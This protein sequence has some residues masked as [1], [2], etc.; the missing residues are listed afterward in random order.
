[1]DLPKNLEQEQEHQKMKNRELLLYNSQKLN[2]FGSLQK[3]K[4]SEP[5]QGKLN[6]VLNKYFVEDEPVLESKFDRNQLKRES[7]QEIKQ[8]LDFNQI[9][10]DEP[11]KS[12][13]DEF[14]GETNQV[15]DFTSGSS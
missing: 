6:P 8:K 14:E 3:E 13:D 9:D 10:D 7:K 1:M 11:E 15:K 5:E 4:E 2:M 12:S